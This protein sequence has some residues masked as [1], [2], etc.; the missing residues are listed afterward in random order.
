MAFSAKQWLLVPQFYNSENLL[1]P[2]RWLLNYMYYFRYLKT[3]AT[4]YLI[5]QEHLTKY[6]IYKMTIYPN[7]SIF[8]ID[9]IHANTIQECGSY[10]L[11][12][13]VIHLNQLMQNTKE[14]QNPLWKFGINFGIERKV[15]KLIAMQAIR[16]QSSINNIILKHSTDAL[17]LCIYDCRSII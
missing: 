16:L 11:Y 14:L 8:V 6:T 12:E 2:T 15:A 17:V 7:N 1:I 10:T 5:S 13:N 3:R 9:R 4:Q